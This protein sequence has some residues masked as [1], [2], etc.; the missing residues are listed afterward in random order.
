VAGVNTYKVRAESSGACP[1][2]QSGPEA[3]GIIVIVP[4]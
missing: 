1:R 4:R 3:V 2:S